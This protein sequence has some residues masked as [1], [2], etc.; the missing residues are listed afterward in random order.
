V[1]SE[2]KTLVKDEV[3]N[4]I[5]SL[6]LGDRDHMDQGY[7]DRLIKTIAE[8]GKSFDEVWIA[9]PYSF[10]PLEER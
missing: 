4:M 5:L 7:I 3:A 10:V 8:S 9:T 6:R 2:D 1:G